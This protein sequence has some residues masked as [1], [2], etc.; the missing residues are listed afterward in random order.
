MIKTG[1]I[2][3]DKDHSIN[4]I[5]QILLIYIFKLLKCGQLVRCEGLSTSIGLVLEV[6]F[7]KILKRQRCVVLWDDGKITN[8]WMFLIPIL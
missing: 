7:D 4:S 6:N 1:T 3:K 5:I 2:I 8:G